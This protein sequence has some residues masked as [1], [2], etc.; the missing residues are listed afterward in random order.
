MIH[1]ISAIGINKIKD[2]ALVHERE[3]FK[4]GSTIKISGLNPPNWDIHQIEGSS[5]WRFL[6]LGFPWA[7]SRVVIG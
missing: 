5:G 7:T 6:R 4:G 2:W 3:Q 1:L